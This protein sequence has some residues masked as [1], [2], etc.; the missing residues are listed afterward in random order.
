MGLLS[1]IRIIRGPTTNYMIANKMQAWI[2]TR[3]KVMIVRKGGVPIK[4][5]NL[6]NE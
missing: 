3:R 2:A 6:L 1:V 4:G 5:F